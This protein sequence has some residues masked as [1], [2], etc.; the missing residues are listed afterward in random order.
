MARSAETAR[1]HTMHEVAARLV[2]KCRERGLKIIIN[3][4]TS[5]DT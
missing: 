3:P 4:D 1:T 5:K 2:R